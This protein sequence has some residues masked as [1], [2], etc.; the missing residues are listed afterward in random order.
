MFVLPG[1]TPVSA[2]VEREQPAHKASLQELVKVQKHFSGLK[3]KAKHLRSVTHSFLCTVGAT[4]FVVFYSCERLQRFPP[5]S[6]SAAPDESKHQQH[7][8]SL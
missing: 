3:A 2:Q 8:F 4:L 7:N 6:A 1:N 5:R